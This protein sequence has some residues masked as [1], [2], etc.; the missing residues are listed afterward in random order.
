LWAD[1]PKLPISII[2]PLS[3]P[4]LHY[5]APTSHPLNH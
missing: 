2:R 3:V 4:S 1:S 5:S